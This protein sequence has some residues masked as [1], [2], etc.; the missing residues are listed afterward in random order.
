MPRPPTRPASP[1]PSTS[2]PRSACTC[3]WMPDTLAGWAGPPTSTPLRSSS[4]RCSRART[5]RPSSAVSLPVSLCF[6]TLVSHE[7]RADIIPAQTSRTTTRSARPRPT[8]SPR[9]I[10]TTTSCTTSTRSVQCSRSRASPH[11][12]SSTR[13]ALAS[14]TSASSGVTGAT[15]RAQASAP[16]R[17][18]TPAPRSSTPSSGSSPEASPTVPRTALRHGSTARALWCVPVPVP[19]PAPFAARRL[20]WV[21]TSRF[22][23]LHYAVRCHRARA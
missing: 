21:L 10:P 15:S 9:A 4:P 1:T 2:S 16:V 22:F 20:R 17:R 5:P 11:S 12:S 14:R 19:V 7:L 13:A 6:S 18:P 3:T 23:F 8:R